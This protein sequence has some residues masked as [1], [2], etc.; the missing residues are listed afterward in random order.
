[1]YDSIEARSS[2][3]IDLKHTKK[4]QENKQTIKKKMENGY[5]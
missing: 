4:K 3:N 2:V 1:M 5:K